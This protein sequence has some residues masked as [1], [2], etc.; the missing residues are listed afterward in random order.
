M[1]TLKEKLEI[2]ERQKE[3][4]YQIY[5]KSIGAIEILKELL[6]KDDKSEVKKK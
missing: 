5:I 6:E 2:Y 4:A 1:D 3:Q